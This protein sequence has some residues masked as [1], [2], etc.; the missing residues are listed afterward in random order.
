MDILQ[1]L[2]IVLF[3]YSVIREIFYRLGKRKADQIIDHANYRKGYMAAQL[4]CRHAEME[5][6]AA[7]ARRSNAEVWAS[8]DRQKSEEVQTG[9]QLDPTKKGYESDPKNP[10][11][12][13]LVKPGVSQDNENRSQTGPKNVVPGTLPGQNSDQEQLK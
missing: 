3:T 11:N 8:V 7:D 4:D 1:V 6:I 2:I 12:Q 13:L 10:H 5:R 9:H